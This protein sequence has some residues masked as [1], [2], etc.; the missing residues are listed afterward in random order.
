MWDPA[1]AFIGKNREI[2]KAFL[3]FFYMEA[4]DPERSPAIGLILTVQHIALF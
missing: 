1:T 3:S 2:Q 4:P